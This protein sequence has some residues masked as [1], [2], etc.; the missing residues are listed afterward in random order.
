MPTKVTPATLEDEGQVRALK[1]VAESM[2]FE[3]KITV[4]DFDLVK[5]EEE[6]KF[7]YDS[8]G[9]GFALSED[10]CIEDIWETEQSE[11]KKENEAENGQIGS[12]FGQS[13]FGTKKVRKKKKGFKKKKIKSCDGDSSDQELKILE[14]YGKYNLYCCQFC[15]NRSFNSKS[16]FLCH[17]AKDH[18]L[19]ENELGLQSPYLCTV[20]SDNFDTAKQLWNHEKEQ[21]LSNETKNFTPKPKLERKQRKNCQ[22][23][24]EILDKRRFPCPECDLRTSRFSELASH[25]LDEHPHCDIRNYDID[26]YPYDCKHC[27]EKL[28]SDYSLKDHLRRGLLYKMDGT[29]QI[30]KLSIQ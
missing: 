21:H 10:D 16:D 13:D 29:L 22:N 18:D 4:N 9:E 8:D 7:N 26:R 12:L 30:H 24:E 14:K 5:K 28:A 1:S 3:D 6:V 2:D 23:P 11:I 20:C 25:F 15:T 19:K 27:D 17:Y